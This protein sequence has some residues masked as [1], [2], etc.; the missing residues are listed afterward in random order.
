MSVSCLVGQVLLISRVSYKS[1]MPCSTGFFYVHKKV[2]T[3]VF[4]HIK[5]MLE[6]QA[7]KRFYSHHPVI[8]IIFI[9]QHVF[10]DGFLN[11]HFYRVVIEMYMLLP[12]LLDIF[13]LKSTTYVGFLSLTCTPIK[14]GG[15]EGGW[16]PSIHPSLRQREWVGRG[17]KLETAARL[18]H[19]FPVTQSSPSPST[20]R[21]LISLTVG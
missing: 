8:A 13:I 7:Q 1:R 14:E 11:A 2:I 21:R 12:S 15:E 19:G 4:C 20:G 16:A 5:E 10:L 18:W 6:R 3:L 9:L 17:R